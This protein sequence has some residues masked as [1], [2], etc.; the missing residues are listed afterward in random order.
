MSTRTIDSLAKYH[1]LGQTGLRVSPLALGTMNFGTD[2]GWDMS[3]EDAHRLLTR[4]LEAGGNFIDTA[5]A[6]TSGSSERIIG[7]DFAQCGYRA[8]RLAWGPGR[9]PCRTRKDTQ[10]APQRR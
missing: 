2:W 1:L 9:A 10:R 3:G 6:Y 4:Y 8:R 5:D 7:D